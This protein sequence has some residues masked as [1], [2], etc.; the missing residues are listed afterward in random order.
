LND[1]REQIG[2]FD[3]T[4]GNSQMQFIAV[5]HGDGVVLVELEAAA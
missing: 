3:V 5:V 4:L 1:W 2:D